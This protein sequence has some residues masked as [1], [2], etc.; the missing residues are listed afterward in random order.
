MED[1]K[2]ILSNSQNL[3][4]LGSGSIDGYL[5]HSQGFLDV[6]QENNIVTDDVLDLGSG[7]GI[8]GLFLATQLSNSRFVLL[9]AS[10]R[11]CQFLSEAV[12]SLNISSRVQVVCERAEI[13]A[14]NTELR[15]SFSL[16]VARGFGQPSVTA[17]CAVPF[18]KVG[19]I[20]LVSEPP[21]THNNQVRDGIDEDAIRWPREGCAKLGLVVENKTALPYSFIQLRLT[22]PCPDQYPRR[23]GVPGKKPLF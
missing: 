2:S 8:P 7:G 15:G 20:L 18:L 4:F 6:I 9:D 5:S 14:R 13:A 21:S 3:G 22:D 10:I 12:Q 17:E 1:I 19:G 16:V 11:R 23:N